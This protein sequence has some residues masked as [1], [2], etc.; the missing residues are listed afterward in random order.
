MYQTKA[1]AE[2]VLQ[3]KLT[4]SCLLQL[5]LHLLVQGKAASALEIQET[6]KLLW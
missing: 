2:V 5:Q 4:Q 6:D 3:L 1:S